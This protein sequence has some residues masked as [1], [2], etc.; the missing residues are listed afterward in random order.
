[1]SLSETKNFQWHAHCLKN[2]QNV[3]FLTFSTN[4]GPIKIDL[5]GNTVWP[6][7][8]DF[9]KL[10]KLTVLGIFNERKRSFAR[11]VEWD[12]FCDF[13]TTCGGKLFIFAWKEAK[14]K[15]RLYTY[16]EKS[17]EL[18]GIKIGEYI[19]CPP[20]FYGYIS[21]KL[22]FRQEWIVQAALFLKD[23]QKDKTTFF[24]WCWVFTL[25]ISTLSLHS[26]WVDLLTQIPGF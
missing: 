12:I 9:Q 23:L 17:S 5:S 11:N 13:Q 14:E 25:T 1:M 3:A 7:S 21:R 16:S 19:K 4:F 8:L 26:L 20:P 10:A 2:T 6:Q 24:G 22:N 15:S 18:G